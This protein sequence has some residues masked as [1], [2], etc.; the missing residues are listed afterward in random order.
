MSGQATLIENQYTL[1]PAAGVDLHKLQRI[2]LLVG[3]AGLVALVIGNRFFYHPHTAVSACL[4]GWLFVLE[5]H[6]AWLLGYLNDPVHVRWCLGHDA[7]AHIGS[8]NPHLDIVRLAGIAD[9]VG[10]S[11]TLQLG[12]ARRSR[13]RQGDPG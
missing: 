11:R 3:I 8:G 4:P 10:C 6:D 1:A 12:T 9:S 2:A 13:A 5:R 7:P